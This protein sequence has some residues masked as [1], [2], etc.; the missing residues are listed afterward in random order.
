MTLHYLEFDHSEDEHGHGAFEAMASV[1]ASRV[2][3]VRAEM[4][5][6]LDWAHASFPDQRAPLEEGGEWDYQ[7]EARQ[8]WTVPEA[9][10]YDEAARQFSS[11]PGTPGEPLHILVLSLS[12]SAQFCAALRERFGL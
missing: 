10:H 2:A 8:E 11:F 12:G 5:R 7:L 6:V 3:A 9:L 1:P 4:A